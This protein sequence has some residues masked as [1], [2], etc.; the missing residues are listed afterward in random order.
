MSTKGIVVK[1]RDA[2]RAVMK[3]LLLSLTGFSIELTFALL[4]SSFILYTDIVHWAIDG[5][6]EFTAVLSLYLTSR[7]YRR[8][9]WSIFYFENILVFIIA[10]TIFIFYMYNFVDYVNNVIV[11]QYAAEVTTTNPLLAIATS[12]GTVLT[13]IS[14]RVLY[15]EYK[16]LGMELIKAEYTHALIDVIASLT[17]TIGIIITAF[18]RS[19]AIELLTIIFILFFVFHS[20]SN[21]FLDSFKSFIGLDTNLELKYRILTALNEI[22]ELKVKHIDLRKAGSFYIVRI[23]CFIDPSTTILRAHKLRLKIM[24][25]CKEISELIYHVDVVF[26]PQRATKKVRKQ[27]R[28]TNRSYT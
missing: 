11:S 20:I 12:I 26:Y 19:I 14:F 22:E 24:E 4:S 8:F 23:Q 1:L 2:Y 15:K 16:R 25:V 18:T 3:V 9:P 27:Y 10:S 5:I 28:A 6:L 21:L 17:T 7:V 13:W